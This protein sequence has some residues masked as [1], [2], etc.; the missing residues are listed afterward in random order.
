MLLPLRGIVVVEFSQYLAGP[1]AGL[2]LADLGARVIKIER[3][4]TG[5]PARKLSIKN[6]WVGQDALNF[7]AINRNK[8]SFGADLKNPEE[9]LLV[10]KLI[11]KADIL[12]HNF[13]PGVMENLGLSYREVKKINP[14]I[15]YS[16]ITGFGKKGP[17]KMK[18]GQDLLVQAISGLTYTTGNAPDGPIPFGLSVVDTVCGIHTVQAILAALIR[19]QKTGQG[20]Y[21]ELSLLESALALQFELF[22]TWF[23]NKQSV[24]RSKISNGNP[25]LGAPYGVYKTKDGFMAL[26]M[27]PL[28][29]L[30]TALPCKELSVFQQQDAFQQRDAIKSVI[31]SL[32]KGQ[33]TDYWLSRL[34]QAGLWASA[35][36]NWNELTHE[37]GYQV[38]DGQQNVQVNENQSIITTRCPIRINGAPLKTPV[39]A[40]LLGQHTES[41][42][43]ELN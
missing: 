4:G 37:T 9:L 5:D 16:E 20:A 40:P 42:K 13:R 7:H 28:A 12:T 38:M 26:A 10:K 21:I 31:A 6:L 41:I 25:L 39:S 3:P 32:L 8:E 18:P 22:T 30:R 29:S 19:R 17:W 27:M 14:Q 2:R 1:S 34:Q 36:K 35:V 23:Q 33:T 43:K 24:N 15:V 11:K